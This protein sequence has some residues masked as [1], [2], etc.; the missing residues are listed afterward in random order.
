MRRFPVLIAIMLLAGCAAP[1]ASRQAA[2]PVTVGIIAFNDFH[3]NIEPPRATVTTP[4]GKGG[5][6]EVKAGGAAWF[7]SAIDN[8]RAKYQNHAVVSAGDLVSGSPIA[9]SL[10]LDEP[11]VG[12]MNRIGLDFNAVGNHEFDRGREELLRLQSGGCEKHT[13]RDPCQVEPFAGADF[14]FLSASTFTE[15]GTTLFPASVIRRFGEGSRQ[16]AVG[17]IGLTLRETATLVSGEGTKGLTFGDEAEAI[18]GA[19]AG[20]RSDGAD[21]V[22]VL[23]HQGGSPSASPDPNGCE[24]FDGAIMPILSRLDSGVDVVVSG[25][26]HAAYVCQARDLG[27]YSPMLLTSAGFYGRLVTDITLSVDPDTNRVV[28]LQA[29]N[30]IV[31]HSTFSERADVAAYV[32]LYSGAVEG[33]KMRVVGKLSAGSERPRGGMGGPLGNLIADSQLAA[34][35]GAGARIAL[36]NPFGIRDALLPA[37][38]GTVTFGQIYAVQPFYNTLITKTL[39]GKELKQV[40]E[41]GLDAEGPEQLLAPSS[42]FSYRFDRMQ[43]EGERITRIILDGQPIDPDASYR[44]TTN[45]FLAGGRDGYTIFALGRDAV[46]GGSDLDALEDWIGGTSIRTLPQEQRVSETL[47]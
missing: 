41:Q 9:S 19:A 22:V 23:I 26:T 8:L 29:S 30:V 36:T 39:T 17:F 44:V 25:H 12:A 27:M 37:S 4:D 3:G 40:L 18:N 2:A 28:A 5:T 10:F 34:T 33:Q 16:V 31:D 46:T 32:Q 21:A 11:T 6:T 38:D 14:A 7:A 43:P 45:S 1:M 24:G 47:P 42:G 13:L 35:R 20:L 15:D